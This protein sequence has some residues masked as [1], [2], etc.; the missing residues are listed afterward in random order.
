MRKGYDPAD[1]IL[2]AIRKKGAF[3][4]NQYARTQQKYKKPLLKLVAEGVLVLVRKSKKSQWEYE[5]GPMW[6]RRA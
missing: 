3:L 1:D 2:G 4:W 6:N 5:K